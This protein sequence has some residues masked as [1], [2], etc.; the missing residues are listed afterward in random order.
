MTEYI[1][2]VENIENS[3]YGSYEPHSRLATLKPL[4]AFLGTKFN[5][6]S[7][8]LWQRLRRE[9]YTFFYN[10]LCALSLT[11]FLSKP[12]YSTVTNVI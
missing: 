11:Y 10:V 12:A 7:Y 3:V 5:G 6:I 2:A 9:E 1:S 4:Y 8:A